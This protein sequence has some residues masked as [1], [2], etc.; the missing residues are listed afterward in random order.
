MPRRLLDGWARTSGSA[1]AP[2]VRLPSSLCGFRVV[3]NLFSSRLESP[4]RALLGATLSRDVTGEAG[5]CSRQCRLPHLLLLLHALLLLLCGSI[6]LRCELT[7]HG[8]LDQRK[9][10]RQRQ[11]DHSACLAARVDE[12]NVREM[13]VGRHLADSGTQV[14]EREQARGLRVRLIPG[15]SKARDERGQNGCRADQ[16][17]PPRRLESRAPV[18][19]FLVLRLRLVRTM[20]ECRGQPAG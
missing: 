4:G 2:Q 17:V 11:A 1:S 14:S 7:L 8:L 15:S 6:W 18:K 19:A 9:G 20:T 10:G 13:S 5:S 16:L 3:G 12:L